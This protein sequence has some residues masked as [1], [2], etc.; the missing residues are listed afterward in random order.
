M[1]RITYAPSTFYTGYIASVEDNSGDVYFPFNVNFKLI[2]NYIFSDFSPY[3][4]HKVENNYRQMSS[5]TFLLSHGKLDMIT[6][7]RRLYEFFHKKSDNYKRK[8]TRTTTIK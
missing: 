2:G 3:N 7:I 1:A 4:L 8:Q 6:Q 5:A